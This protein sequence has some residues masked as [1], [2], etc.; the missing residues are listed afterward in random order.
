[1]LESRTT[2][3]ELRANI[4]AAAR[5]YAKKGITREQF[6]AKVAREQA[7]IRALGERVRERAP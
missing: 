7:K 4:N 5:E 2:E 1:M 6:D 3:Q